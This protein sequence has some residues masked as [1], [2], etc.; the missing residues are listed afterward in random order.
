MDE[1]GFLELEPI[2]CGQLI[3]SIFYLSFSH[4]NIICRTTIG[5]LFNS[6]INHQLGEIYCYG[7]VICGS[8]KDTNIARTE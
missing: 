4:R 5:Y 8:S 1:P 7:F 6:I 2:L 3:Q